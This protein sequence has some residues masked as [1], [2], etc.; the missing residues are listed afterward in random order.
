MSSAALIDVSLWDTMI[1]AME[2]EGTSMTPSVINVR[3]AY[4]CVAY[5]HWYIPNRVASEGM[6]GR[7]PVT[8]GASRLF[9]M[10]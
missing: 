9:T 4:R 1:N 6:P 10:M 7:S 2:Q 5:R 3:P 8:F